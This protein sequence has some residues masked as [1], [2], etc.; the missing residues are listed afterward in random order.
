M[1]SLKKNSLDFWT[2]NTKF[3]TSRY[4]SSNTFNNGANFLLL[5]VSQFVSEKKIKHRLFRM[6]NFFIQVFQISGSMYF[7]ISHTT[8]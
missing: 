2:K 8:N 7:L 3:W 1:Y 6:L 5:L 4:F